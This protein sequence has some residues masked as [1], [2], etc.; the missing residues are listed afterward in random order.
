[1]VAP[2]A[3]ISVGA[4]VDPTSAPAEVDPAADRAASGSSSSD[5]ATGGSNGAKGD[6]TA[7][8]N[9]AGVAGSATAAADP[10]ADAPV[11]SP[12]SAAAAPVTSSGSAA[13]APSAAAGTMASYAQTVL[14]WVREALEAAQRDGQVVEDAQN[15]PEKLCGL[16]G[17]PHPDLAADARL[18]ADLRAR[19]ETVTPP[20]NARDVVH[21]PL[22]ESMRLWGEGLDD[23]NGACATGEPFK[24]GLER[25]GAVVK[26]GGAI[27]AFQSARAGFQRLLVAE[28]LG[29]LA[30]A[31]GG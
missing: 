9:T 30:D 31:L 7:S 8:E 22:L 26:L 3:A 19:L 17:Q 20:A 5:A 10:A 1:M 12:G 23:L 2:T 27:L 13:A 15:D 24:Q 21:D 6:D 25:A 14:P 4:L 28:G 29:A 18:M 11:T 16:G